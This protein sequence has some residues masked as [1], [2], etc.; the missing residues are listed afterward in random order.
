MS[1]LGQELTALE[2]L[3][4]QNPETGANSGSS[5]IGQYTNRL[6]G[7]PYQLL[8]SVDRRFDTVNNLVGN[9]YLR[10]FLLN[11]P[12][13]HIKPGMPK[14]TGGDDAT[15]IWQ[16]L[17]NVYWDKMG[18]DMSTVESLM[19]ELARSKIFGGVGSKLQRRM[20]GFRETYWDYMQYVNYMCRSEAIMLSLTES[21]NGIPTGT[22]TSDGWEDFSNMNWQNY[23]MLRDSK[24]LDPWDYLKEIGGSI[25]DNIPSGLINTT[26]DISG[27]I[28]WVN[29][30]TA[31][32]NNYISNQ[33][34]TFAGKESTTIHDTI[35][36]KICS[37]EF[38]VDPISFQENLSNQTK[39]SVIESTIDGLSDIGSEIAFITNSNVDSGVLG[40]FSE[41]LGD[42]AT[43]TAQFLQPLTNTVGGGFLTNL[44]DGALGSIKGQKMIYPKIYQKS[45]SEMNYTFEFT[46]TTPYGDIYNYYMNIIVPL[47]HLIALVSPRMVTSNTV[48]SP[49]LIQCYI[50]GMCTC[51]LGI[52][53]SLTI[54]KNPTGKHVS[55][56]G[57]PLTVKATLIVEE[58]YNAMS[59]SPAN[60][61]S[62]FLFNET[63]NDYMANMAGLVPSVDTFAKQR[64]AMFGNLAE[65]I[66]A[67]AF[68]NDMV[69]PW[70]EKIEN[71]INP[72]IGK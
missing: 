53:Q 71:K 24:P 65:Y 17:K 46:F 2:G 14:Y 18:G 28:S 51:Q 49:F 62:S 40:A 37:V 45:N 11:S 69:S 66:S 8:D 32:L 19:N 64:K 25:L 3:L 72:F 52:A 35:A 5:F 36:N 23:R 38:M 60:D 39:D 33:L 26:A 48:S 31:F 41:F 55:V 59:I 47:M 16:S 12:I 56:N 67:D 54:Q 34:K 7:A 4:G 29:G 50:P 44:F 21:D 42:T 43:T 20:F 6:F 9:E 58:L 13:L 63:L 10:N 27:I 30:S 57:F 22:F 1:S 68:A 61:P 70:I 15:T